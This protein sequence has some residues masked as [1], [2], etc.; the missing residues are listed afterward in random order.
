M[1]KLLKNGGNKELKVEV[2]EKIQDL[3]KNFRLRFV[4]SLLAVDSVIYNNLIVISDKLIDDFTESIFDP[5][6]NLSHEPKL[7]GS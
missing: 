4:D 1:K 6:I 5:G 3:N 2:N 7:C